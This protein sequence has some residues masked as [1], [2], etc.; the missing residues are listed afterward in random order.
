MIDESQELMSIRKQCRLL[1]INRSGLYY[2]SVAH[3]K[4]ETLLANE[5]Y[6]IWRAMS[7]YGYRK[8]TE[9]LHDRGYD[10]N[11]K[12]TLKMMRDMR[13]QALY[14]K[15]RTTIRNQEHKTYPYLLRGLQIVRPNQV[16]A[17]DITYIRAPGGGFVYLVAIID[18][19]SRYVLAWRLS[20]TLETR[21]CE[22]M[23]KDALRRGKPEILNT[24]QG[25]Q[26]TSKSWIDLVEENGILVSMDGQGRWADNIYIERFWRT[27]KHEHLRWYDFESVGDL[28]DSIRDFVNIYNYRRHHQS[29]GYKKPAEVYG[30]E[31]SMKSPPAA[32]RVLHSTL[33][34]GAM[35]EVNC[36]AI[37]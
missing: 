37:S 4:N 22:D 33:P 14:P 11:A 29:L 36:G 13:I 15:P 35:V 8:I 7:F 5:I 24:D 6:G 25:C 3:P 19:Y 30:T 34:A 18:V 23:L 31:S 17:T 10:I 32:L 16:W 2:R 20:N 26:F 28:R 27:I 1:A 21:F 9:E 12:K